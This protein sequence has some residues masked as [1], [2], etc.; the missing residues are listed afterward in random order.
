VQ[1]LFRHL[2]IHTS[3]K[4]EIKLCFKCK[5]ALIQTDIKNIY[6]CPMCKNTEEF[7]PK[8]QTIV[9]ENI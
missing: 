9:E 4:M 7:L 1:D 3:D 8:D 2:R 5:I 6:E